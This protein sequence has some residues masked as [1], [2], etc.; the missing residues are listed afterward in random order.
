MALAAS[1]CADVQ[2]MFRRVSNI[3]SREIHMTGAE[4]VLTASVSYD[5]VARHP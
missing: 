3:L 4:A 1:M 5:P 2:I